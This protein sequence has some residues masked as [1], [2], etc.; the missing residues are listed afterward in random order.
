MLLVGSY[1]ANVSRCTVH[2]MSNDRI[3]QKPPSV[4][5]RNFEMKKGMELK[6]TELL[7]CAFWAVVLEFL[8]EQWRLQRPFNCNVD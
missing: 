6:F 4:D 8:Q 5:I 2:M 3:S 1:Y 7:G